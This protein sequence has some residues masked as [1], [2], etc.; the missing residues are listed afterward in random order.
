MP[1]SLPDNPDLGQLRRQAKELRDAA[2]RGDAAALE[3]MA[4]H[5]PSPSADVVRLA[6]AQLVIA[7]ELGFPSW[8]RLVA[9]IGD[10]AVSGEVMQDFLA[11][12]VE[13]RMRRAAEMFRAEPGIAERSVLA[14]SVLGDAGAVRQHLAAD[15][16][17]AVA[18]DDERGWPPLLYAC[19]SRW[20]QIDPGRATG[21]AEVVRLLLEAGAPADTNDGGQPKLRAAL[22]GSV[23][24]NNPEITGAL[25]EAGANPNLG[26]P[27]AEAAGHSDLRC[28]RL[29][30][31]RGARVAGT[32]ALGAAAFHDNPGAARLLLEAL[33]ADGR[34]V[35]DAATEA[36]PDA[37]ATAS[38]PV[39]AALLEAGADPRARDGDGVSALRLAVRAGQEETATRLRAAGADED[40]TE[41]DRFL[42]ACLNGDR[43]AAE[44]LLASYPGLLGRLGDDDHG[45]ICDAAE[46]RPAGIVA[47]MLDLGF[48]PHARRFGEQPLHTA[49]YHGNAPAVRLLLEAGAEVDA[50]DDRFGATSLAFATVGSG[51][52]AGQPGRWTETVRLLIEAGA[53]RQDVWVAGKPPSEEVAGLLLRYGIAPGEP[54]DQQPVVQGEDPDE[55]HGPLGTGV[56]AEIAWHLDTAYGD[57]DLDLL[58]S[59][60]H[61]EARWTGLCTSR[62]QVLD[63]YRALQAEGTTATVRSV[64][65]DRDAVVLGLTVSRRAQGARPAPAQQLYQVFTVDAGQIV[66]IHA[67][68]DRDSALNRSSEAGAP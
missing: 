35:A 36:L 41:V 22:R 48:S 64:Q 23:E 53:S 34:K 26:Q 12:S 44:R 65:V 4:R 14:A 8:P 28:L 51:E 67:Y 42:G 50:V 9:A 59:L 2:R 62:T 60:L 29:I 3:R 37:A 27:V 49:A 25:L 31:S 40:G 66:E 52:Q 15:P 16:A 63:W 1:G 10:L 57:S 55:A 20:H 13:G 39:V 45:V 33:S 6:T 11:A 30:L 18:I 68:P 54:D 17:A 7:R 61:P 56:M 19:Y 43:Q 5:R 58:G 32:W 21:L 47:L 38:Y 46:S 24:V